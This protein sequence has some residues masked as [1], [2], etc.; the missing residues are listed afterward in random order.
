VHADDPAF[1]R[2]ILFLERTQNRS[3]SNTGEYHDQGNP[4]PFRS[5]NDGGAAYYPGNSPA[6]STQS[7]DGT[8]IARSYGSMTYALLKCYTLAG[9]TKDDPRVQA[10]IGWI[11]RHWTLEVNPGFDSL[12]DPRAGFQGLYYY[13]LTLAEALR[14]SGLEKVVTP[15]GAEH[16]WAAELVAHLASNQLEDGSWVNADAPR[17]WE[18]NPV[19]CTAYALNT[20]RAIR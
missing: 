3:E 20:Y 1:Q 13:Y 9:L 2:A 15:A 8:L 17:W 12:R 19:L 14:A 7:P 10:A 16:D 18:G 5:G 11:Q 4:K 6:G